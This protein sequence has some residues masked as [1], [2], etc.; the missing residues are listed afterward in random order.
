MQNLINYGGEPGQREARATLTLPPPPPAPPRRPA[1]EVET[2][3]SLQAQLVDAMAHQILPQAER[4]R[5]RLAEALGVAQG[6]LDALGKRI[7]AAQRDVQEQQRRENVPIQ[8]G[9]IVPQ[10]AAAS[11]GLTPL[12]R[13]LLEHQA[14]TE[15]E[16]APANQRWMDQERHLSGLRIRLS[17]EE[18]RLGQLDAELA[19][20]RAAEA[21]PPPDPE[22]V[23]GRLY[24]LRQRLSH[25][26]LT[27]RPEGKEMRTR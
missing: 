12:D 19:A 14:L 21:L 9:W 20:C 6:K 8:W 1:A 5:D 16:W 3:R 25:M 18:Q 10:G 26:G 11:F 24:D 15:A 22:A 4:S 13:L 27:A 7:M 17:L 2:E 23:G